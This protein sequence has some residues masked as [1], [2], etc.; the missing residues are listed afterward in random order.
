MFLFGKSNWSCGS[1]PEPN[2]HA[3]KT[4]FFNSSV[5]KLGINHSLPL[6]CWQSL[7]L[8]HSSSFRKLESNSVERNFSG[9]KCLV[10]FHFRFRCRQIHHQNAKC[11]K[12]KKKL[13]IHFTF[14]SLIP[15]QLIRNFKDREADKRE[16]TIVNFCWKI[17][18]SWKLGLISACPQEH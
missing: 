14:I 7:I 18:P 9:K 1:V 3:S 15:L 11:P 17:R 10:I 12:Y 8:W 16:K 4:S 6:G 2:S 5:Q 13:E